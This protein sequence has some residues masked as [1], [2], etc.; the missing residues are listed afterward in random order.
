MIHNVSY[1]YFPNNNSLFWGVSVE[2][3]SVLF[4]PL[5]EEALSL[6]MLITP[7]TRFFIFGLAS[8]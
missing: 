6:L 8:Y 5:N 7:R 2:T 3:R 1:A 4:K